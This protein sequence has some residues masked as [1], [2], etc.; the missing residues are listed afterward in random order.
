MIHTVTLNPAVDRTV[1]VQ[2]FQINTVNRI[3]QVRNDAGGKGINVSKA[4]Q[5]LRSPSKAWGFLGGSSGL[6]IRTTLA[7]MEL[8]HFFIELE[9]P[10]RT[11]IKIV[12]PVHQTHTDVNEAGPLVAAAALNQ[13]E[14]ELEAALLP[15]DILVLSGSTGN[16]ITPNIYQR[17]ISRFRQHGIKCILDADGDALRL[18]IQAGPYLVKPNIDELERLAGCRLQT[19]DKS[20][21]DT[22]L[23]IHHAR[24]ILRCGTEIVVVSLGGEGAIFVDKENAF[25]AWGISV[26]ARST[27]GA[28]DSLVAAL[29][30]G[31]ARGDSLEQLVP[32][33]IAAGTAA[34]VTDGSAPFDSFQM[35]GFELQVRYETIQEGNYEN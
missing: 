26:D 33:A 30:R 31:I 2:N 24:N 11:N 32:P 7:T 34:A 22:A 20:Q 19:P 1:V 17:W 6:F 21:L 27:V 5:V 25:R 16:G 12:D 10:T 23:I 35:A 9:E 18:G 28:G 8:E 15:S 29:A 14:A 3:S 4:L 13:L